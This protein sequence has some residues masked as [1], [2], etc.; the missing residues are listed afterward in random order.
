MRC[1]FASTVFVFQKANHRP[2]FILCSALLSLSLSSSR[3]LGQTFGTS[4]KSYLSF[5]KSPQP[6]VFNLQPL[7]WSRLVQRRV[8]GITFFHWTLLSFTA[9]SAMSPLRHEERAVLQRRHASPPDSSSHFRVKRSPELLG[10]VKTDALDKLHDG[11]SSVF[12]P[13]PTPG[14]SSTSSPESSPTTSPAIPNLPLTSIID[15]L[16]GSVVGAVSKVVNGLTSSPALPLPP[17]VTPS[18]PLTPTSTNLI[19]QLTDSANSVLTNVVGAVSSTVDGVNNGLSSKLPIPPVIPTTTTLPLV[20][21]PT[22]TNYG[23]SN[24]LTLTPS[25]PSAVPTTTPHVVIPTTSTTDDHQDLSSTRP[26][27]PA[28][29]T[30]TVPPPVV[31]P[32]TSTNHDDGLSSTRLVPSLIPTTT[33]PV[34]TPTMSTHYGGENLGSSS[35]NG[36]GSSRGNDS[37]TK[38]HRGKV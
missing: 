29:P 28:T 8:V 11:L 31:T 3:V 15:G 21:T 27:P 5:A 7:Q 25:F 1:R 9:F 26:V 37:S 33:A 18:L 10:G 13:P 22:T 19:N 20:V 23:V 17:S 34:V 12:H 38:G 4:L 6:T 32:T 14:S 35:Y 30:T 36:P 16:L 2:F 24:P